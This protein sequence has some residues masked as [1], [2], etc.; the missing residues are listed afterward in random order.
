MKNQM[1]INQKEASYSNSKA[2]RMLFSN[3]FKPQNIPK[4]KALDQYCIRMSPSATLKCKIS[5]R[6]R[7]IVKNLLN[8]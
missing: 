8:K 6:Q 7:S 4:I 1:S 3:T 2:G 5:L